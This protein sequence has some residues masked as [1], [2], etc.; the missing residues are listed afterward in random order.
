VTLDEDKIN[1]RSAMSGGYVDVRRSRLDA[2]RAMREATSR[3]AAV[4]AAVAAE[5]WAP[6]AGVEVELTPASSNLQLTEAAAQAAA[7]AAA[8]AGGQ[9]RY[10]GDVACSW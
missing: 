3:L 2:A 6:L 1:R 10:C 4:N 5:V 9:V 7:A 8:A